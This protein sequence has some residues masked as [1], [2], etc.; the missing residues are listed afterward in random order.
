[1]SVLPPQMNLIS[2]DLGVP[3]LESVQ[4]HREKCTD[5]IAIVRYRHPGYMN[6]NTDFQVTRAQTVRTMPFP[7]IW[8]MGTRLMLHKVA[9]MMHS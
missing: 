3:A 5:C 9:V 7:L 2:T 6:Y 8:G 4:C 1:M